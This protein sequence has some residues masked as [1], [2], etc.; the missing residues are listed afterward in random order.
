MK[1]EDEIQQ[2]TF[3]SEQQK[4]LINIIYTGNW[5]NQVT[6][7]TLKKHNISPQQFNILRILRGQK[8]NPSTILLLQERMLDKLSNASRLVEKLRAKGLV[9]R[10]MNL[11]DRRCVDVTI[12]EKGLKLLKELEKLPI[13]D[14]LASISDKDAKMANDVLDKARG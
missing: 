9:D 13:D 11:E 7:R 8:P 10:K 3:K 6:V 12:T 1:L 4:L 5:I 2:K 14:M